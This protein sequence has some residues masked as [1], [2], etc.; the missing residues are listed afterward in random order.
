MDFYAELEKRKQTRL[1][2]I[3]QLAYERFKLCKQQESIQKRIA[4]I[5]EMIAER[6]VA[7]REDDQ[8]QRNFNTYLA[9]KEGAMTTEQLADAIKKGAEPPKSKKKEA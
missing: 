2:E 1:G 5:D 4:E 9:I 8:A 6:E 3:G 7:I